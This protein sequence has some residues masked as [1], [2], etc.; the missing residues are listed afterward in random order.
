MLYSTYRDVW[1]E[2]ITTHGFAPK[3]KLELYRNEEMNRI[4]NQKVNRMRTIHSRWISAIVRVSTNSNAHRIQ[5]EAI[6]N[7]SG[8]PYSSSMNLHFLVRINNFYLNCAARK[9]RLTYSMSVLEKFR[10]SEKYKVFC[11][12]F[13]GSI[14]LIGQTI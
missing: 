9:Y 5:I 1:N 6:N 2:E 8:F 13:E 11:D 7:S 3:F 10:C 4:Q 12:G 14:L